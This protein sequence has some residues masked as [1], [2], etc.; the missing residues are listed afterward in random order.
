MGK[1]FVMLF[2]FLPAGSVILHNKGNSLYIYFINFYHD[3]NRKANNTNKWSLV[4]DHYEKI[5]QKTN[6]SFK[7]VDEL[8]E[9]FQV[10]RKDI[11][12][13][14]E[15]WAKAGKD[16]EALL[17]KKRGPKPGQLKILSKE[18]E[19]IIVKIHRRLNAN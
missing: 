7:T 13:Y 12:K 15:R 19:R 5:K 17:S 11:R 16:P 2:A 3:K 1:M 8:C 4:V 10:N 18:E 9:A 14:Y 6:D